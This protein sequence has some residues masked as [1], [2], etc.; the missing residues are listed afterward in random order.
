ML[1]GKDK[2]VFG[3]TEP[4]GVDGEPSRITD[5]DFNDDDK[6]DLAVARFAPDEVSVLINTTSSS[7]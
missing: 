6:P 5:E 2:G 3:R 7:S 4:F 1:L